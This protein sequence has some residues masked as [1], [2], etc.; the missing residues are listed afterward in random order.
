MRITYI[1]NTFRPHQREVFHVEHYG[2]KIALLDRMPKWLEVHAEDA[3]VW[4]NGAQ[5][6]PEGDRLEID[7]TACDEIVIVRIAGVTAV[8]LGGTTFG[9]A[10][11]AGIINM[12]ISYAVGLIIQ[13][14]T[15]PPEHSQD[16]PTESSPSYGF[17]GIRTRR[18]EGR[19]REVIYGRI[20]A[21]GTLISEVIDNTHGVQGAATYRAQ[22]AYGEGPIHSIAG[23][24]SDTLDGQTLKSGEPGLEIPPGIEIQGNEATNLPSVEAVIRLGSLQQKHALGFNYSE[25]RVTSGTPLNAPTSSTLNPSSALITIGQ[26]TQADQDA[27]FDEYGV[28]VDLPDSA[29]FLRVTIRFPRGYFA[30]S[31]GS[32]TGRWWRAVIR[33]IR[34]DSSGNP[35]T[36][37]GDFGDGWVRLPMGLNS[38]KGTQAFS[39]EY[40]VP[41]YDPVTYTPPD[42]GYSLYLDA[43]CGTPTLPSWFIDN[44]H[45]PDFSFSTWA[46]VF[47]SL[48]SSYNHPSPTIAAHWDAGLVSGGGPK[49][50]DGWLF[51]INKITYQTSPG[52]TLQ[53]WVPTVYLFKNNNPSVSPFEYNARIYEGVG[54][55]YY[56]PSFTIDFGGE[57]AHL[58]FTYHNILFNDQT[59]VRIYANGELLWEHISTGHANVPHSGG[60]GAPDWF[61]LAPDYF[62][63]P[64]HAHFD[65]AWYYA[66]ERSIEEIRSDYNE[67]RGR[68]GTISG[69]GADF[70]TLDPNLL[71]G[72]YHFDDNGGWSGTVQSFGTNYNNHLTHGSTSGHTQASWIIPG[73][74]ES[75]EYLSHRY[76]VEVIRNVA[77]STHSDSFDDDVEL[78]A[79]SGVID[80]KFSYPGTPHLSIA[81]DAQEQLG[82][83]V[84]PITSVVEGRLV[85][86]WDGGSIAEPSFVRFYDRNVAATVLDRLLDK[87]YGFGNFFKNRQIDV[88]S[89]QEWYDYCN[90][91]IYDLKGSPISGNNIDPDGF[92]L[93]KYDSAVTGEAQFDDRGRI[94]F[95]MNDQPPSFWNAG[96]FVGWSGVVTVASYVDHNED[97]N[98]IGGYEI[99]RVFHDGTTWTV[100]L[101]W[102]R[103]DE[104]DPW[105]DGGTLDGGSPLNG[106]MRGKMRRH[107]YDAIHDT[108]QKSW[109]SLQQQA[110]IG[111]GAVILDG[112]VARFRIN[113]ARTPV[114]IVSMANIV[115]DSFEVAYGGPSQRAN[116]YTVEFLDEDANWKRKPAYVEHS[117]VQNVG[118][119]DDLRHE[120]IFVRGITRRAAAIRHAQFLV[121]INQEISRVGSFRA[122]VDSMHYEVGDIV[123]LQHDVM[124]WG[125]GGRCKSDSINKTS[126]VLDRELVLEAATTYY[127]D[128]RN[129]ETGGF[130]TVQVSTAAGT[131]NRGQTISLSSAL[132]FEPATEDL[133]VVWKAADR[134]LVEVTG[135][136]LDPKTMEVMVDWAEYVE[137]IYDEVTADLE[138][139]AGDLGNSNVGQSFDDRIPDQPWPRGVRPIVLAGD[140]AE[141]AVRL[142][143]GWHQP[144]DAVNRSQRMALWT[145]R[146]DV[147]DTWE[148]RTEVA[149]DMGGAEIDLPGARAGQQYAVAFQAISPNNTK[150]PPS[151]CASRRLTIPWAGVRPD[152]PTSFRATMRGPRAVYAITPAANASGCFHEIRRGGW[153]L[154]QVVAVLPPGET[155]FGPTENWA[156]GSTNSVGRTSPR[157]YCRA[158]TPSGR[159]STEPKI[160]E[161]AFVPDYGLDIREAASSSD[162]FFPDESWEDFGSGWAASSG[163]IDTTLTDLQVVDGVAGDPEVGQ[164]LTFS[165]SALTGYFETAEET[166][167]KTLGQT[168]VAQDYHLE[169]FVEAYQVHPVS[170][171][172]DTG[173]IESLEL[174]AMTAEG[175]LD[176]DG[177]ESCTLSI[178]IATKLQYEDVW[179]A[180][181]DFRPGHYYGVLFKFRIVAT[182]PDST[183]DVRITR[184][185]QRI[186]RV[187]PTR[188]ERSPAE[189]LMME[190]I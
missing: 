176:G 102:D 94:E 40:Q 54:E 93:M 107:T 41:L 177:L 62:H 110:S 25:A 162:E 19:P 134:Q 23:I 151:S 26:T 61:G 64:T 108:A 143:V 68:K 119:E 118:D 2:G 142:E 24:S 90:E 174:G 141:D 150:R 4:K 16:E 60:G 145:K 20:R 138:I 8:M 131:W 179:S 79:V 147:L 34:L 65:E 103:L 77:D 163:T 67:G 158:M 12:A 18:T 135:V 95:V 96:A 52:Q 161:Q 73:A 44:Q 76:R 48:T 170:F 97:A 51:A 85:P 91:L 86:H 168:W 99:E 59:R 175:P 104:G 111:R 32:A 127:A 43:V 124:E 88:V 33:Y 156:D 17:Q 39:V 120:S 83:N 180:W 27:H 157:M 78:E 49:P 140:G 130:E 116:A 165:G 184:A 87:D 53:A 42:N 75:N 123:V 159:Y 149:S 121:N 55:E 136:K 160:L 146:V 185:H 66:A 15:A 74:E 28:T 1:A 133:W 13:S 186:R 98:G 182:R 117:S 84:P 155:V 113:R 164:M 139:Q 115:R 181:A 21:G 114:G 172:S 109:Q 144:R 46:R 80:A 72:G 167:I 189:Q 92:R 56:T 57:A 30:T 152:P 3:A 166:G 122:S 38:L 36:T 50:T 58:A 106:T 178:Q 190:G 82:T 101:Y 81:V 11:L 187:A 37:G 188:W 126:F 169:F 22:I 29:D 173:R 171:A 63:P 35:I 112:N 10:L 9:Y 45:F 128:I 125:Q 137:S 47:P 153:I 69:S 148:R 7:A 70:T 71:I 132:T 183:F 89:W 14:I 154:G 129:P 105:L 31:G 100:W 6:V 5:V